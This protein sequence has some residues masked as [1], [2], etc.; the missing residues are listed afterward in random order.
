MATPLRLIMACT[1]TLIVSSSASA[2]APADKT[3]VI[4]AHKKMITRF[5]DEL[6]RET[7]PEFSIL[8]T[9]D[10][11]SKSYEETV[12]RL[13]AR[14]TYPQGFQIDEERGFLYL[15]R[16]S[17]GR[18]TRCVIEKYQWK[19]GELIMTYIIPEPQRSVSEGLVVI[20]E[21]DGD[22]AYVRSGNT[23]ARLL[24]IDSPSG[25]GTTKTLDSVATN[26]AQS[27]Y[28]KHDKWFIEKF[29]TPEDSLGE[30][31]GQYSILDKNFNSIRDVTFAPEYAGY[32]NS[33]KLGLPKHQGFAVL[34]NGYA[35]TM[36]G[37]WDSHSNTTPYNYFGVNFF[38][39]NG[40]IVKSKYMSPEAFIS[41]IASMGIHADSIEN[42]GLQELEDGKVVTLQVI[43]SSSDRSG[44]LLFL[45][46]NP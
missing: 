27:F 42:E 25:F 36:G 37:Y 41:Q 35:M 14:Y 19:T 18:P 43:R 3:I 13:N 4:A 45:L 1:A 10:L 16:Y 30:S 46:L 38:D 29:K 23:L 17:N 12:E 11:K 40:K 34:N 9:L 31:R 24:L 44:K 28:H 26:V 6:S 15:L 32:R 22:V 20:K 33:D 8:K 5:N 2:Q 7:P 39:E 21:P